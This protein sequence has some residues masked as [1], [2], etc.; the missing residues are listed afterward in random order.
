MRS[1]GWLEDWEIIGE[2]GRPDSPFADLFFLD[3]FSNFFTAA[4]PCNSLLDAFLLT[5][6]QIKR[7]LSHFLDDVFLLNFPLETPQ[8]ILNRF[9]FMNADFGQ[10]YTPPIH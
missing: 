3:Y 5:G 10:L 8:R 1:F 7:V 4:F 6:F 2:S 9:P